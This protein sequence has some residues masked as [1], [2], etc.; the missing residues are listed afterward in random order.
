MALFCFWYTD[1]ADLGRFVLIIVSVLKANFN[2]AFGI[3]IT[4]KIRVNPSNQGHL[5]AKSC[6]MV[7]KKTTAYF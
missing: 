4:R 5:C 7:N 1:N 3:S 6:L 2:S